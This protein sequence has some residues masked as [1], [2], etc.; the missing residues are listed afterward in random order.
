MR[1]R[2]RYDENDPFKII[3]KYLKRS[4]FGKVQVDYRQN[5]GKGRFC[6][7]GSMSLQSIPR[8]IRHTIARD[9][10]VDID[11]VNAHPVILSYL[12]K[13][14]YFACDNLDAYINNREP[15]LKELMDA[16]GIDRD[17]AKQIYLALTNG[18]KKDFRDIK[19]PTSHMVAYKEEMLRLHKNF[20]DMNPDDFNIVRKKR[21][22]NG[23]DFNHEAGYMNTLLCDMENTLLMVLYEF[24]GSPSDAVFCFDGIMLRNDIEYDIEGVKAEIERRFPRLSMNIKMKT[25]DEHFDMSEFTI[26]EYKYFS[27][28]YYTDF[29]NLVKEKE[30]YSEWLTEWSNNS[31]RLIEN[32]G[33]Q[34]FITRNKKTVVFSDKTT[35][36]RYEWSAIKEED[37]YKNLKVKCNVINQF[38]DYDFCKKYRLMKPKEKKE[39]NITKEEI[40]ILTEQYIYGTIGVT[41]SRMGEGYLTFLMEERD[42]KSYNSV[43]YFPYIIEKGCPPLEDTFNIFTNFPL[44]VL[45]VDTDIN[46]E[47]S[48]IYKH[49]KNDF[50]N[51]DEGELNHFIDHMADMIQDPAEI[52]GTSHLFYSKQGCGKGLIFKFMSRM[53]GI[54]NVVSINNT[55]LYFDSNFNSDVRHKL[56]KV[57]E[58][59]SKR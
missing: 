59:V 43:D 42:I 11:L 4:R 17:K 37:I 25:M 14:N 31:L 15:L 39:L 36:I 44:D 41:N 6:A 19:T 52:K 54:S 23:K 20:A 56:L 51:N 49:M 12:C 58:E 33:S 5:N 26:P 55:D 13:V 28:E 45:E 40:R 21:Q 27:L 24:F 57:F 22:K 32:N 46:F 48:C 50:F 35:E 16:E 38:Q 30:I 29:R 10:Y 8:E 7:M 18:G 3:K 47:D 1:W 9:Y 34:Y 53:L 2:E